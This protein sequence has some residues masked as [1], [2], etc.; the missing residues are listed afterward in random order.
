MSLLPEILDAD[1]V[2]LLLEAALLEQRIV[3]LSSSLT[4]LMVAAAEAV[5]RLLFP[6]Q[7]LHIYIPVL[8]RCLLDVL[9]AEQPFIIGCQQHN[10]QRR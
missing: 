4:R 1:N 7:W 10:R 6:F 8:P 9:M 2:I 3:L 5:R